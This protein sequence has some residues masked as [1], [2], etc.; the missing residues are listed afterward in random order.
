MELF[1]KN[2]RLIIMAKNV[3][4]VLNISMLKLNN[5]KLVKEI[6]SIQQKIILAL[7]LSR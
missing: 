7:L 1:A 2:K 5:V 4:V 6:T 3:S